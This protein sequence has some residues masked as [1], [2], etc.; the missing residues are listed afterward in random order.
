MEIN[1]QVQGAGT[2]T[3]CMLSESCKIRSPLSDVC[4]TMVT[5]LLG[6][7]DFTLI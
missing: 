2:G 1:T 4:I 7:L 5:E 6:F 3:D